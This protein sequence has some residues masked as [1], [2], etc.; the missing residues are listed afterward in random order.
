MLLSFL[1]GIQLCCL[2]IHILSIFSV[3]IFLPVVPTFLHCDLHVKFLFDL[4]LGLE[5]LYLL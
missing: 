3:L 1:L 5:V 4:L 2:L